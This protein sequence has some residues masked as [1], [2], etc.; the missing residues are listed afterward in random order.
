MS[1]APLLPTAPQRLLAPVFGIAPKLLVLACAA[2]RTLL[3]AVRATV[4]ELLAAVAAIMVALPPRRKAG[5]ILPGTPGTLP[6]TASVG[7][8]TA[9]RALLSQTASAGRGTATRALP[10]VGPDTPGMVSQR[11]SS[12]AS[13]LTAN[14]AR[15]A[16]VA[17]RARGAGAAARRRVMIRTASQQTARRARPLAQ[18]LRRITPRSVK[19][20]AKAGAL[21]GITSLIGVAS[22][23]VVD[24]VK[25]GG[26]AVT[27]SQLET[28]LLNM[29]EEVLNEAVCLWHESDKSDSLLR[30]DMKALEQKTDNNAEENSQAVHAIGMVMHM[31]EARARQCMI[32]T[33]YEEAARNLQESLGNKQHKEQ[34]QKLVFCV[35]TIPNREQ[36]YLE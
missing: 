6:R 28:A 27:L 11:A 25:A 9:S 5:I 29:D 10:P 36:L 35:K 34:K 13:P 16:D 32:Q 7:R 18:A 21:V 20:A 33:E 14:T 3:D 31:R 4:V 26:E 12:F 1:T 30:E 24:A 15:A 8:M 22:P 23:F 19:K 17:R 2:T